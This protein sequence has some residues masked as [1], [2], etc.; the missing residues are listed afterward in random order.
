MNPRHD[1]FEFK[2]KVEGFPET[3]AFIR[4]FVSSDIIE[5][6]KFEKTQ[7]GWVKCFII[8]KEEYV[9]K[10]CMEENLSELMLL[11]NFHYISYACYLG[12][13]Y[14]RYLDWRKEDNVMSTEKEIYSR[15]MFPSKY[16]LPGGYLI[17]EGEIP[18]PYNEI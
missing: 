6:I 4:D 14:L 2:F 8:I 16:T 12:D 3:T 7:E 13:P 1:C 17:R 5:F 15:G 11:I 10:F 9:K 18:P